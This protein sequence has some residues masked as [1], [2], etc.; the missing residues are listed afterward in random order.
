MALEA[1]G[2]L[3]NEVVFLLQALQGLALK[4]M[5][6]SPGLVNG[7]QPAFQQLFLLPTRGP[8]DV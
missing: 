2:F 7:S 4:A 5:G 6:G 1:L 3:H 8:T